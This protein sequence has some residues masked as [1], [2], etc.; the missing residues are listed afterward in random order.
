MCD[1][2][3]SRLRDVLVVLAETERDLDVLTAKMDVI[4]GAMRAF[5]DIDGDEPIEASSE[6]NADRCNDDAPPLMEDS[7]LPAVIEGHERTST[8]A[9]IQPETTHSRLMQNLV[10]VVGAA[11]GDEDWI[12]L[13]FGQLVELLDTHQNYLGPIIKDAVGAK[14]LRKHREMSGVQKGNW[15]TTNFN[16]SLPIFEAS[17]VSAAEHRAAVELAKKSVPSPTLS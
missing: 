3:R 17:S 6:P 10:K 13:T 16:L 15:F 2:A 14:M 8:T 1:H 12:K 7:L 11:G 9:A 5:A 4:V